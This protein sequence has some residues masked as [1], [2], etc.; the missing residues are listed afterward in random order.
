M[1]PLLGIPALSQ[2]SSRVLA[3]TNVRYLASI[4]SEK[5]AERKKWSF[6]SGE[7]AFLQIIIGIH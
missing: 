6:K 3:L 7:K 5:E 4:L 2:N 1:A